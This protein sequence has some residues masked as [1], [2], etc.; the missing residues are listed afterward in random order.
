MILTLCSRPVLLGVRELST[1][2]SI[3]GVPCHA[4]P[5]WAAVVPRVASRWLLG[6]F[7]PCPTSAQR[8]GVGL[9]VSPDRLASPLE[10]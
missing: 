2:D 5:T 9:R 1:E 8:A 6:C 10:P 4:L 3:L 7:V